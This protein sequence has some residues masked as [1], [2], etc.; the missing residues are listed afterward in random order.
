M[1]SEIISK[2]ENKKRPTGHERREVIRLMVEESLTIC[3]ILR[4]KHLS[5]IARKIVCNLSS[6]SQR[7]Y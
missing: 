3:P 2:L 1:P 5:E 4:K 6:V 7:C